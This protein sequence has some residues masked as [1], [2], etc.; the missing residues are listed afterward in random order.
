MDT[1]QPGVTPPQERAALR[2]SEQ[3]GTDPGGIWRAPGRVNLI[4]EHTDYNDGFVLPFAIG[5]GVSVAAACRNDDLIAVT[6]GQVPGGTV[7]VPLADLKPGSVRGW[8]AYPAGV[9]WA[10]RGAGYPVGGIS[11]AIDADLAVGSG[12]SSSAALECA[13]ALA[14]IDLHTITVPRTELAGLARLAENDFVGAPTGIMDQTAVLCGE[15]NHVLLLDCRT[16]A[17]TQIPF[18]L[19]ALG[20]T[21]V[22][23]D[24]RARHELID[25]GYATRRAACEEAARLLGVPALRDIADP[26][27]ID[28]LADPVLRRRARH[29]VTENDRVLRTVELLRGCQLAAIGPLLTA[30]H[31]SLRDDFEVSW[32]QANTAVGTAISAGALGARMTGGGFGGSVIAMAAVDQVSAI[33][34]AMKREFAAHR[35]PQPA[36]STARPSPSAR[37]TR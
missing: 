34:G 11:L 37:R 9:A 1:R 30:S 32:P 29:V 21:I 7:T 10:L 4:G 24:T 18:D 27:A 20:L 25:G 26:G 31:A 17:T 6:S 36:F 13:T 2:F 12:L 19:G 14:M 35:W 23:I 5:A 15:A 33:A 16:R 8:A 28:R 3:F 22:I